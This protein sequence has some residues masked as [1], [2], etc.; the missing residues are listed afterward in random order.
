MQLTNTGQSV[1]WTNTTGQS[2]TAIN[3]RSCIPDAPA[4]GGITS[5][6]DLYVNGTLRQAFSVNSLQNYCYEGTNY[7]GQA[8]KNPA[9]NDPRGFWNDTHAFITGAPLAPGDTLTLQKDAANTAAFYYIDVVDL[10]APPPPLPQPANS[11][12]ILSYGAVSNNLS[13]DNTAAINNCFAA[14]RAQ[15][16]IAWIPPGT[17]CISAINGGLNATGITIEGAGPWYSMI[18]RVTPTNNTQGVANIINAVSCTLQNVLLDCNSWSRDGA[19]NN[20]AV[21]FA[22]NNWVVNNVWIQHTTSSFWCAGV[23]GIAENCRTL[24][25]W[26]DGG[27][28]N[29]VQSDNGLGINLVYSNNFVR[30]TGDDAM[31]IN[32]VNINIFGNNTYYYTTMSNITYVNNTAIDAWGGKGI[33][34]YGGINV[35]VT[36]NLLRDTARYIGLGVGKFGVN[37]SDLFSAKVIGNTVLRCGGNGYSQ[38]QPGMMIG[39]GGDGQSSGS[40]A[41]AYC[42]SN[43]IINSLYSGVGFTSSTNIV[44]QYN[45]IISPGLDGIVVG[46]STLSSSIVGSAILNSN[47]VSGL[48]A[49]H[50]AFTNNGLTGYTPIVP[51][52][53][54]TYNTAS[55]VTTEPCIEGGQDVTGISSGDWIAFNNLRFAN[56][57]AFVSRAASAT[58]GGNIEIHLDSPAGTLVGICTVPGTGGWQNYTDSYC[59]ITNATGMHTVYLVFTGATPSLFNVEFFGFYT[60]PPVYSHQLLPGNTYALKSVLNGQYVSATNNGNFTLAAQGGSVSVPEE[61]QIYNAGGGN[62]G[63]LALV[64]TNY[65]TAENAGNS[66]L[67]ANRTG[68]G[69]WE[70]FTEF[71]STN[72]AIAL[73]AMVNGKYVTVSNNAAATLIAQSS[74]VGGAESFTVQFVSGIVPATPGGLTAASGNALVSLSW[75]QSSGATGYNVKRSS[76]YSGSYSLIASNLATVS[77]IDTNLSNGTTYYY[78]VSA[79]NPAGESTNSTPVTAVAGALPRWNWAASASSTENNGSPD[80]AIDG[81]INT[82]W[83]TGASQTSG[84]WFQADMGSPNTFHGLILDA[85]SSSSDY[86]RGYQVNISNDGTNWGSP[87]ATGAGSAVTTILFGN[88]TARFVRV[89]QTTSSVTTLWWSIHEFNALGGVPAAPS[90]LSGNS[91]SSSQIALSWPPSASAA[92]YNVKRG[93]QSGGPYTN[94]TWNLTDTAYTDSGLTGGTLYYYVVTGTNGFGE[95]ALSN[96]VAVRPVATNPIALN[97]AISAGKIQLNWPIDHTGWRLEA[98]TNSSSLGLGTNWTT[99]ASSMSTNT[100]QIPINATNPSVFFRLVYP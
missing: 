9:D 58:T 32:S 24:S 72:G 85:A 39:N 100:L 44:F 36:N 69:L 12:S 29:N 2:I 13:S 40:V 33:G 28:F 23:N 46:P 94:V 50:F 93:Q 86:P 41:N 35:L 90:P 53:A 27:N 19:N 55:G 59:A 95:S 99:I 88:Q 47:S 8:D 54:A 51:I 10:E 98:Q 68:V 91:I 56:T 74:S 6:I 17:F 77:Y 52:M 45:T 79:V 71:A 22:G 66:P 70:T 82:R 7:N 16:K 64:D 49:G 84:Q 97:F 21:D 5:T 81:N 38:Q 65:V 1:T 15:G 75:Q 11:L 78:A 63:F 20:G 62:I 25:T 61:F 37:G 57:T 80:Y 34:I 73:A 4:G 67:I 87:I 3:I 42:A 30:G 60:A 92:G 18:Y 31:A 26:A 76:A 43:T 83:S 14:A 96:E 48:N 89:T